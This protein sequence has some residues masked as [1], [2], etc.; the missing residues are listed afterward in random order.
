VFAMTTPFAVLDPR[1]FLRDLSFEGAHAA[2]GH[3]GSIG[4]ASFAFHLVHLGSSLGWAALALVPLSLPLHTR[5]SDRRP[6][7]V[8]IALALFGFGLP[9][10]LAHIDAERYLAGVIPF[11]ALLAGGAAMALAQRVPRLPRAWRPAATIAGALLVL[12]PAV[13]RGVT[14]AARGIDTT[15]LAAR[16]WCEANVARDELIVEEGYAARLPS[17]LLIQNVATGPVYHLASDA[18]RARF[19]A[20]RPFH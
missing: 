13:A 5:D 12:G 11:A 6:A 16:R 1:T 10:S 9:I 4:H 7:A 15:Q 20:V 18:A 14:T 17:A 3:F 8:A 2:Q 19:D